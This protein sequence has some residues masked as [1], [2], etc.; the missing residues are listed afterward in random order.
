[1]VVL[2]FKRTYPNVKVI[3]AHMG[4]S[5]AILSSRCAALASYM[6]CKLSPEEILEDFKTFYFDTALG[7][8]VAMA[9]L[10]HL[11]G[12]SAEDRILFGTDFPGKISHPYK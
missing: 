10:Q 3:L 5:T 2:G 6:G 9:A 11:L 1:M 12:D 7:S 8:E 4:G